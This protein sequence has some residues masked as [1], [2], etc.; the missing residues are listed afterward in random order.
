M[1]ASPWMV[2]PDIARIEQI[3]KEC[4]FPEVIDTTNKRT[5]MWCPNYHCAKVLALRIKQD[6]YVYEI[7]QGLKSKAY[8]VQAWY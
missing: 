5:I 3:A 4:Q 1:S 8:Y 7:R 2:A 6:G